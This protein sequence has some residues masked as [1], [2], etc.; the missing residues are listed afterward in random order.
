MG[1]AKIIMTL[2]VRWKKPIESLIELDPEDLKDAQDTE[3]DTD[4][5]GRTASSVNP[6]PP[7]MDVPEKQEMKKSRPVIKNKLSE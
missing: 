2:W 6:G 7:E 3:G 4:D 5:K 1:F